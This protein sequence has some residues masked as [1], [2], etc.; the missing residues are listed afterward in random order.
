MHPDKLVAEIR[1]TL[2]LL[3]PRLSISTKV[4]AWALI[5]GSSELKNGY[6]SITEYYIVLLLKR[7]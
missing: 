2:R 5:S 4:W 1:L 6:I 7:V 3:E